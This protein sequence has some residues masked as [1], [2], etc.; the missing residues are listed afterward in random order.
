VIVGSSDFAVDVALQL[1]DVGV[2]IKAVVERQSALLAR[3]AEK[4]AQLKQSGIPT[5]VNAAVKEARGKG[6]VAEIDIQLSERVITEHVDLVCLDGGRSPVLEACYQL[7]CS[8]GYQQELGGWLPQYNKRL[9]TDREDV[10]LA[11]NAAGIS[12]QGVVLATGMIAGVSVCEALR[13]IGGEEAERLR[14]A[15]WK[16]L[17]VLETTLFPEV[18][19]ARL[20]HMENFGNP[21]LKEQFIS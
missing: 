8:F 2:N 1:A 7:G 16:E 14:S 18:W 17:E 9:Q 6:E 11:G 21:L 20:R 12:T 19:Q 15:L 5:Y 10:F 4:V 3:D 13:V